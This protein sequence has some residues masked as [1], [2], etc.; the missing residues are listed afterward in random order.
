MLLDI[1]AQINC[2]K[3]IMDGFISPGTEGHTHTHTHE[4]K[5]N[6]SNQKKIE[7]SRMFSVIRME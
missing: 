5:V 7:N 4:H 6:L 1:K 3:E 2:N